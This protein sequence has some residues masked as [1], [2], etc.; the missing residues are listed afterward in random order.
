MYRVLIAALICCLLA[1][2]EAPA[3]AA[4]D[5]PITRIV[6]TVDNVV[7]PALVIDS[8]GNFV[9]GLQPAQ[10]R[11]F[12]NDKEQN[13]SVDVTST[14]ISLVIC[15]Q[16]NQDSEGLLSQVRKIGGLFGPNVIGEDGEAAVI[17]YDSRVRTMQ[18]FTT[19]HA[20]IA[21]A[22]AKITPGSYSNRM[23][24]AVIE[25]TRMLRSRPAARRRIMLLIGETRDLGSE[26]HAR[27]ALT[28]LQL[29]NVAFYSAD[30]SRFMNT[31]TA[32]PRESR[33]DAM[34]PGMH[35]MPPGVAATPS[36]VQQ[37]Y[38]TNS[39]SLNVI[40]LMIEIY[41]DVK[42]VFKANP[43]EVFTKGTG[44]TEFG[45]HNQRSLESALRK[46]S[47]QLH[48]QYLIS[49]NP[50]NKSEG[51]FHEIKVAIPSHGDYKVQTRPGY[52]LGPK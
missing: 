35:P 6:T 48:S 49:Y 40:P 45:F 13:I 52:Y 10:F 44:G 19:D 29:A 47:E 43:V 34:P 23:V 4:G 12:D 33:P 14:P 15:V 50:N 26:V 36:T 25:G 41:R 17:A 22:I 51:G 8:D 31:M 16:S 11:L 3:P 39:N 7:V 5:M 30:M 42:S 21:Q 28:A 20:K 9:N 38:G 32:K 46:I 27:E 18:E 1:A 2:Q 24:D 37:A